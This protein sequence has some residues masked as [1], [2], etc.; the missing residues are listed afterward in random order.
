[1]KT[2]LL[3]EDGGNVCRNCLVKKR[4]DLCKRYLDDQCMHKHRV[5]NNCVWKQTWAEQTSGRRRHFRDVLSEE[6]VSENTGEADLIVHLQRRRQQIMDQLRATLA[7]FK[8]VEK[9]N[10]S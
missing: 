9:I 3:P 1:M 7:V 6:V 5:C 8:Y 2:R 4:C 10:F